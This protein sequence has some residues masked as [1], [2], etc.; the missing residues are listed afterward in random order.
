MCGICGII[1]FDGKQ[2][3]S[4]ILQRMNDRMLH[5][6]PDDE[7][8]FVDGSVGIAARR[9]SI[10][11]VDGG[12]QPVSRRDGSCAVAQ[13]GEIYN[14][15]ELRN[16]LKSDHGS[17]F[18]TESDTEVILEAYAAWGLACLERLNGMFAIAFY[19]RA[20]RSITLARDRAG[21]KPLVYW[22]S[23]DC[24]V[25]ASEIKAL[26]AH[27]SVSVAPDMEAIDAFL[28]YK[29]I[30]GDRTPFA[31]IR[32]LLPGH[33]LVVTAEGKG[34]PRAYWSLNTERFS[35]LMGEDEAKKSL[36]EALFSAVEHQMISD[37]PLGAFLSG[38]IDSTIIS[39]IMARV[40]PG[41]VKTFCMG[42]HE[43]SFNELPF[44]RQ[45]ATFHGTEHHEFVCEA[46]NLLEL[47]PELVGFCDEP[48]GDASMI[49]TYLVARETRKHVTVALAGT[50][51]DEL[52]AGYDRHRMGAYRQRYS[53]IP[54]FLRGHDPQ[55][56]TYRMPAAPSVQLLLA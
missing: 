14:Y 17:E 18:R 41:R 16:E 32:K 8:V 1:R 23:S 33:A 5:R 11:D 12:H 26:L 9:L 25:F 28:R 39:G 42:F 27:P 40:A 4:A 50:G 44:A 56:W 10:I 24:L 38:G 55:D 6:G 36:R 37:V 2:P 48:L 19:D 47:V 45:A 52:F 15:R 49:P 30:P 34:T 51:A 43:E 20:T 35:P 22:Q 46:T 13:N 3:D 21:I 29:Y 7:G 53:R 54:S 31:G